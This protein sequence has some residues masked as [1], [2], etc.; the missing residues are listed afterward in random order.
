MYDKCENRYDL[1]FQIYSTLNLVQIIVQTI[2]TIYMGFLIII[3]IQEDHK[4]LDEF[5]N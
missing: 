4:I 5:I 1:N 2:E 3:I